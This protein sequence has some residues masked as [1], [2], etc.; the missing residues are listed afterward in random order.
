M[1]RES[2]EAKGTTTRLEE[3]GK[4]TE[5][6]R[7]EESESNR[8]KKMFVG[9]WQRTRG[10][11]L[12]DVTPTAAKEAFG[13][14][15]RE[16]ANNSPSISDTAPDRWAAMNADVEEAQRDTTGSLAVEVVIR[17]LPKA[18]IAE[19][20]PPASTTMTHPSAAMK[21]LARKP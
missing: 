10:G 8:N 17:A 2:V 1:T 6:E 13:Q 21:V 15:V 14:T 7:G 11:V 4:L 19:R 18:S 20:A 9:L 12:L 3:K 16:G 5:R